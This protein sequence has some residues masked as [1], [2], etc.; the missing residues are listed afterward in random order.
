MQ[1]ELFD[2]FVGQG[3]E[4]IGGGCYGTV[5]AMHGNPWIVKRGYND[6]TRTYLEWVIL[7]TKRGERMRG[8]PEIDFL[9]ESD[10]EH[11]LVAMKRYQCLSNKLESVYGFQCYP[12]YSIHR[13]PKCPA[14]IT[15][16]IDAF[17][18]DCPA[19]DVNDVHHGNV[20]LDPK[21]GD[22]ILTDPSSATYRPVGSTCN[23][24]SR[25][26]DDYGSPNEAD[27]ANFDLK[28]QEA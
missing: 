22:F 4:R 1:T 3:Y 18:R 26:V 8:M 6:G 25:M 28:V 19:V 27:V 10:D 24:Y 7:K 11:Y 12:T 21:S 23:K 16:L 20:M 14:Y 15:R 5:Y 17:E 9:V 13:D 2:K